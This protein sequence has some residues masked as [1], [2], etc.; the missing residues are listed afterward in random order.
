[1]IA[2]NNE[3]QRAVV[4]EIY[5][6]DALRL[7]LQSVT[8]AFG[9]A[10]PKYRYAELIGLVEDPDIEENPEEKAEEIINK[11]MADLGGGK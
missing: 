6:S 2:M 3:T 11:F 8:Q 1:M 9:G 7:L 10:M 5:T 4:Y